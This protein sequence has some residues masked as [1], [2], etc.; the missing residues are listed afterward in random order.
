[1]VEL[2]LSALVAAGR[3]VPQHRPVPQLPPVMRDLALVA[4]E[5][6]PAAVLAEAIRRA[7]GERCESVELFDL[8]RGEGLP[9]AHR[10]LGFHLVFRDPKAASDPDHARTL[11]DAEVDAC[12]AA[13]IEA[14]RV[15]LGAVVRS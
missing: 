5:D 1:V 12:T 7:A 6:V 3:V 2:D 10:S 15:E 11:T 13:V 9:T 4:S 14:V 8:Y